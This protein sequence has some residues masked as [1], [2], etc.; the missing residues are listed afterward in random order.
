MLSKVFV[1]PSVLTIKIVLVTPFFW[2]DTFSFLYSQHQ[3][4]QTLTL[5]RVIISAYLRNKID[6]SSLLAFGQPTRELAPTNLSLNRIDQYILPFLFPAKD[7]KALALRGLNWFVLL[8]FIFF[9]S[10]F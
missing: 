5:L 3:S 10:R 2:P 8:Y 6:M 9:V 4:Q 1:F 7:A